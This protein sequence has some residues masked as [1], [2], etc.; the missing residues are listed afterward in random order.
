MSPRFSHPGDKRGK[1]TAA[2]DR[3]GGEKTKRLEATEAEGREFSWPTPLP[4]AEG[5]S[6]IK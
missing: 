6:E 1:K 2:H 4:V 3:C 5:L